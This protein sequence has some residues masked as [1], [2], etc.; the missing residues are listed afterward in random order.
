MSNEFPIEDEALLRLRHG[1]PKDRDKLVEL[2]AADPSLRERLAEWDQQDA[3]LATLYNP[4]TEEPVPTHYQ[5]LITAAAIRPSWPFQMPY[6]IA[7]AIALVAFGAVAGWVAALQQF[8]GPAEADLATEAMR[9]FA[10]YTVEVVHPVEV[11]ASD[12]AH[13][14]GWL[15]KRIGRPI[16][17]P[18]LS[19]DGF[20]LLGGRVVPDSHGTAALM[21]YENDLGQRLTLYVAPSPAGPETAFRFA[22]SEG[23]QGFWWVDNQLGCALV[24]DLPRDS[25]RKIS[26]SAYDQINRS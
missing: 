20:H 25:L 4:L 10:T 6:R 12:A 16:S 14:E 3:A 26:L 8:P 11:P 1:E 17:P 2:V 7:A 22:K 21:M 13:L 5:A 19:G 9:A 23:A 18:D 24:G 15:S